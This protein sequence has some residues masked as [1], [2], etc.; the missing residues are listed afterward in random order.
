MKRKRKKKKRIG[1]KKEK[2]I[3]RKRKKRKKKEKKKKK[4]KECNQISKYNQTN[5]KFHLNFVPKKSNILFSF[6]TYY[7][8]LTHSIST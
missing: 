3:K 6:T 2:K 8:N 5:Y 7:I 4:K 1:K